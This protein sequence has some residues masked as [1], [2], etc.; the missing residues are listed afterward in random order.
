MTARLLPV[1]NLDEIRHTGIYRVSY[2]NVCVFEAHLVSAVGQIVASGQLVDAASGKT[3][4][5][6]V[7]TRGGE[8][9][10]RSVSGGDT[11]RY[12]SWQRTDHR[13]PPSE[14]AQ[15]VAMTPEARSLLTAQVQRLRA[16]AEKHGPL[17]G[18]WDAI[19][20]IEAVLSGG[21][22]IIDKPPEDW[23]NYAAR[24]LGDA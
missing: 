24:M 17:H 23:I 8:Y 16:I 22:A 1:C 18:W 6:F 7:E 10:Y 13:G 3:T 4:G 19:F 11:L 14:D 2:S 12:S 9:Y 5:Q 20:D 21:M 15:A